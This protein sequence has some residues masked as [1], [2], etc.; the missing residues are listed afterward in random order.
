MHSAIVAI[1]MPEQPYDSSSNTTWQTF[2]AI[3]DRLK[4]AKPDTL[5]TQPG[6]ER[7]AESVW[8]VNFR[9]NPAALARLVEAAVSMKLTYRILPLADAPQWLPVGFDP[10]PT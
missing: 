9:E 5:H 4:G 1:E 7:L 3:V 2:M 6:V 10:K 8:Q